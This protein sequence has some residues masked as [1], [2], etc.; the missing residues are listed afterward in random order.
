MRNS[1]LISL[2]LLFIH[3]MAV[4]QTTR[5]EATVVDAVTRVH[6]PF[7]SVYVGPEASTI[8]NLDGDFLIDCAPDDMLR[9]SY[10]G[11][12]DFRVRASELKGEVA[13]VPNEHL[14]P[15][16]VVMPVAPL[17][18]KIC[19]ETLKQ[20]RNHKHK[21]SEFFYRQTAFADSTCYEFL[22]AFLTGG[23]GVALH[24]L[25][26]MTGRYA[27]IVPDSAHL[28]S[29]FGNFYTFSE[30][31][32]AASYT[33]PSP[34]TDL[35]PLFRNFNQCYKYSYRVI[36]DDG[37]RVFVIDFFPKPSWASKFAT[38]GCTLFVDEKTLHLRRIVGQGYNFWVVT[39]D[40]K[41]GKYHFKDRH[42][43]PT[44][45]LFDVNL[46]EERGFPEV[47]SVFVQSMHAY[48]DQKIITRSTLFNL[49]MSDNVKKTSFFQRLFKKRKGRMKFNSQI[50]KV[51]EKQGYDSTF[52]DKNEIVRRTTVEQEVM[53]LFNHEHLFGVFH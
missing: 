28:Y 19:K 49:S 53:N 6:L 27:G 50:Q 8:T 33:W 26:L 23:S 22:E 17:I 4:A 20:M 18:N 34:D 46:T 38:I 1:L 21:T 44:T 29:Y 35:V 14:L 43:L 3:L 32:V 47:Q 48:N 36:D 41:V 11:Y 42:L 5:F 52:W 9:I 37:N 2:M 25:Q 15:D 30:I 31:V 40:P 16:V 7:A 24:D 13:L 39:R 51:I 10:V 12:R 45:F